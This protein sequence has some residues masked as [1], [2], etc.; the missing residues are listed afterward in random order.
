M[1]VILSTI[2]PNVAQTLD[3]TGFLF[4]AGASYEAGY[5]L[6][7]V[8]TQ[9]VIGGLTLDQRTHLDEVLHVQGSPF[10]S[11]AGTPNIE[12]IAD[13]IIA[14]WTNSGDPRSSALE[15]RL[16]ELILEC[17]LSVT[18][19]NLDYHV[20]F[21][22]ALKK[23]A[24]GLPCCVWIFTTNY[25]LLFEQA[26]ALAGVT[27]ENGFCGTTHR[28]FNSAQFRSCS[29]SVSGQRFTQTSNLTV[30]LLKL[31]GSI[32]WFEQDGRFYEQHPLALLS[33]ARRAMVLPR[34][35]KL[36]ETLI[37]PFDSIFT[38]AVRLLGSECRYLASCGFNYADEHITQHVLMPAMQA[39][40]CRLFALSQLEPDG[41]APF[42][43][44]PNY[45]GAFETHSHSAG[46]RTAETTD[47]WKFSNFIKLFE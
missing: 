42:N 34:R 15:T 26:A 24:F 27:I 25:D 12:Q 37:P 35:R 40:K 3:G 7:S 13:F 39:K 31:H 19:P 32:S 36:M 4:G 29:G 2:L 21:L 45:S 18:T 11:A 33:T 44:M 46:R 8:L 1:T 38:E 22:N 14:H 47:T 6:M 28:F 20:R 41:V 23:R 30:K 10:D 5:P 43:S 17:I 9:T 16:R